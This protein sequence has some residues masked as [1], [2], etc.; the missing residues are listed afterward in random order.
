MSRI[1]TIEQAAELLQVPPRTVL[2]GLRRGSIPGR[3]IGREWRISE[4]ALHL[5]LAGMNDLA[6]LQAALSQP[7]IQRGRAAEVM[8]KYRYVG[9]SSERFM[10]DKQMEIDR[11]EG[12]VGNQRK[13]S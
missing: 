1:L 13:K 4:M 8:G 11:E 2:N 9:L 3:K 10:R 7:E 12:Q 6:I 5:F